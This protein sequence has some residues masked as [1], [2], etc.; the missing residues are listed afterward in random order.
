MEPF[1]SEKPNVN[2]EEMNNERC[3]MTSSYSSGPG[4]LIWLARF[5]SQV[6]FSTSWKKDIKELA[7]KIDLGD[8]LGKVSSH[9]AEKK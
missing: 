3:N 2:T 5:L 7:P 1:D 4:G 8:N 9:W 6:M